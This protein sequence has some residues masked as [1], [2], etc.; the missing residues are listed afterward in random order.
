M[1]LY[2]EMKVFS[3]NANLTLAGSV[4]E[5]LQMPL[6]RM[7]A[8]KFSNDNTFVRYHENIRQRDVFLIQSFSYP[9][10]D[11]LMELL[12]MIDAAKRASAGRITAVIPYYGYGRTDKKDQPRV[13]ITARLI[14]DLLTTAG[15]DRVLTM[16]LH[17]GQIQGFFNIPVDELTALPSL[18]RYLAEKELPN[19]VVVA[20]D[21]GI[22]KRARDLAERLQAPLAI[23]E[24]R[25]VDG[26]AGETE[27][28]NLIGEV[29]GKTAILMDDEVDTGGSMVNAAAALMKAGALETYAACTHGILSG[30]AVARFA[31]SSIQELVCTD[32]IPVPLE[33]R[34]GQV[35]VISIAPLLGEAIHRIHHGL[36]VGEMFDS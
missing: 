7:D 18:A 34:N 3:G 2:E 25:R 35:Q 12:I 13:P 24:K 20:V 4:V 16:D 23:I 28:L 32:T 36:S 1:A 21:I 10:N 31:E 19:P 27:L 15:A 22:S 6:G 33:K 17:A 30:S 14:A 11:S 5:Y 8:F 26:N 9:V 29:E